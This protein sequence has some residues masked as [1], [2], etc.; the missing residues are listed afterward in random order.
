MDLQISFW[1]SKSQ[2]ARAVKDLL[3][4]GTAAALVKLCMA[5]YERVKLIKFMRSSTFLQNKQE[6]PP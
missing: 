5:P 1:D 3:L 2:V 6:V 4:G